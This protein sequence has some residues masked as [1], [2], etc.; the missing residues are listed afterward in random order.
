MSGEKHEKQPGLPETG[1]S[2]SFI[3]GSNCAKYFKCHKISW[4]W[5]SD[6]VSRG[7]LKVENSIEQ[8]S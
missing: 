1:S 8:E 2:C 6:Q 7:D 3:T 4:I 5:M